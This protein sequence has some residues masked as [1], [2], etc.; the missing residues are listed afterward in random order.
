MVAG[1]VCLHA[2]LAHHLR[3]HCCSGMLV[4]PLSTHAPAGHHS[5]TRLPATH[6]GSHLD[7]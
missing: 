4:H 3:S 1:S 5:G 6:P 2:Y 7:G